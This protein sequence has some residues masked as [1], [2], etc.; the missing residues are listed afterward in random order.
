MAVKFV[1]EFIPDCNEWRK[2]VK[3]YITNNEEDIKR[4]EEIFAKEINSAGDRYRLISK[5][6]IKEGN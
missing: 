6:I 5:E 3:E 1:Y 2:S 4:I